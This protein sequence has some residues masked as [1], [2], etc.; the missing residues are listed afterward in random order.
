MT[1]IGC[2]AE[3]LEELLKEDALVSEARYPQPCHR[4]S[5]KEDRCEYNFTLVHF[6]AQKND[7][8]AMKVLNQHNVDSWIGLKHIDSDASRSTTLV[9][10]NQVKPLKINNPMPKYVN[11]SRKHGFQSMVLAWR[12]MQKLICHTISASK[13]AE[14]G[15]QK[16]FCQQYLNICG[17]RKVR[18]VETYNKRCPPPFHLH[19]CVNISFLQNFVVGDVVMSVANFEDF[20]AIDAVGWNP[21][22]VAVRY[23]HMDALEKLGTLHASRG[24]QSVCFGEEIQAF[25][26][27]DNCG[28]LHTCLVVQLIV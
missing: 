18:F 2:C 11:G 13:T 16:I 19:A 4:I 15:V 17:L 9:K 21:V 14:G 8:D 12:N 20:N 25:F 27:R 24:A 28:D 6:A 10:K 23:N 5:E 3:C 7:L 1:A 26:E 22:H